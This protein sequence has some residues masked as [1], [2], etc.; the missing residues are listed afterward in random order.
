MQAAPGTALEVV[1]SQFLLQLL[2]TLF[3]FPALV[4]QM[5]KFPGRCPF[6]K[7]GHIVFDRAITEL[8]DQQPTQRTLSVIGAMMNG[9]HAQG[10]SLYGGAIA[11]GQWN[12]LPA[13]D[14]HAPVPG[15]DWFWLGIGN[16]RIAAGATVGFCL[17][18]Y[19]DI[20][21]PVAMASGHLGEIRLLT[22]FKL[23]KQG[24]DF[25]ITGLEHQRLY[26]VSQLFQRR[27]GSLG[28][29]GQVLHGHD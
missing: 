16:R 9:P 20:S 12:R 7:I 6:R 13:L 14:L 19:S 22:F 18:A 24:A 15:T 10:G 2:I 29:P 26:L 25:A 17:G 8:L 27:Q 4:S 21:G 28:V 11:P 23:L 1:K 3:N 5:D